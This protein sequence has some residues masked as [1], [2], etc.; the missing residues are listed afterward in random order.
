MK[1]IV[2]MEDF[3]PDF[4]PT[5]IIDKNET[6][7]DL[8]SM[9]ASDYAEST[10]ASSGAYL[11]KEY[12][13]ADAAVFGIDNPEAVRDC[14][15]GWNSNIKRKLKEAMNKFFEA[16]GGPDSDFD[17]FGLNNPLT[18]NLKDAACAANNTFE[19]Y[20]DEA[21]YTSNEFGVPYFH[22]LASTKDI[23]LINANPEN[24]AIIEIAV[25]G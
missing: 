13:D 10:A 18:Q 1:I 8:A 12:V 7:Q 25:G 20:A 11:K 16:Y 3:I 22:P 5:E 15:N 21:V 17:G 4:D 24:Y 6:A 14:I 23:D 9:L 19:P 2:C